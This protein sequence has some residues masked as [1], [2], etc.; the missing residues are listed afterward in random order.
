M[1]H[2]AGMSGIDVARAATASDPDTSRVEEAILGHRL[3]KK[4]D[5]ILVAVSGGLDSMV[6][7]HTLHDLSAAHRWKLDVAHCNHQLRGAE[8][9]ADERFVAYVELVGTRPGAIKV[10]DRER[11]GAPQVIASDY[12]EMRF[13]K[14][15]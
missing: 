15:W 10:V 7:L 5:S 13:A 8:S 2:T 1:G 11:G 3:L 4:G 6:L 12:A 9:D 14:H